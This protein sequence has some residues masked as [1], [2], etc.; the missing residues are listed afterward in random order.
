MKTRTPLKR[1]NPSNL[2]LMT[3][4]LLLAVSLFFGAASISSFFMMRRVTAQL[5]DEQID[6]LRTRVLVAT[7]L[8][9]SDLGRTMSIEA[10]S[11]QDLQ[12]FTKRLKTDDTLEVVVTDIH[13]Q[14]RETTTKIN[15]LEH[16]NEILSAVA[17][18]SAWGQDNDQLLVFEPLR[19]DRKVVGIVAFKLDWS[20]QRQMLSQIAAWLWSSA[21]AT[22]LFVSFAV[23]FAY[24][25]LNREA[26]RRHRA[27]SAILEQAP[28]GIYT[29]DPSG[30]IDTFNPKMVELAGASSAEKVIGLNVF[31]MPSY[32]EANLI[33]DIR[34]A[35]TG[36]PFD[37]EVE[38]VSFTAG[39]RTW[40]H[41]RGV[42]LFLPGGVKLDR[43]L[44]LVEDITERKDLEQKNLEHA[45]QVEKYAWEQ[46]QQLA[47][48]DAQLHTVIDQLPV[49]FWAIDAQGNFTIC[50]GSGLTALGLKGDEAIGRSILEIYRADREFISQ[51]NRALAGETFSAQAAL[52]ER[53]YA[54]NYSSLRDDRGGIIGAT[55]VSVD[56]TEQARTEQ[57]FRAMVN[58]SVDVMTVIDRHGTIVFGTE[59]TTRVFGYA[60]KDFMDKPLK[61]FIHPDDL[62]NVTAKLAECM[63]V[64]GKI[65]SVIYRF[66]HLDGHY[67]DVESI[68]Q[69]FLEE[70]SI[71]G[72]VINTR[73]MTERV[74]D[75]RE[76][77]HN[78][79]TQAAI[80][81]LGQAIM[82]ENRQ[83]VIIEA[84]AK[85]VKAILEADAT[86][87]LE[88]RAATEDFLI[89]TI[90]G[91]PTGH[92]VGT[93]LPGNVHSQAG[94]AVL[95]RETV[96]VEDYAKES[97]FTAI[98]MG[99]TDQIRSGVSVIIGDS[100][101]P[102]GVL[103][104]FSARPRTLSPSDVGFLE[105]VAHLIGIGLS[106]AASEYKS[107]DL[108]HLKSKFIQV[109]S[110][111]FRAPLSAVRWNLESLLSGDVGELTPETR[112]FVRITYEA[113]NEVINRIHDLLT[114]LDIEE[115]RITLNPE[116]IS[117]DSIVASVAAEFTKRAALKRLNFKYT[118]PA[119]ASSAVLLDQERVRVILEKLLD[120]ALAY[121]PSG[122][123][124]TLATERLEGRL[125]VTI[126]DTGIG[127]PLQEQGRLFERFYRASNASTMRPD[128]SGLGLTIAKYFVEQQD[129]TLGFTSKEG[130]GSTFW[131]ELPI[132]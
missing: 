106:R 130:G 2:R 46:S 54:H 129:G 9:P 68:G 20:R 63:T 103:N 8:L 72:I 45:Q 107:R 34:Q 76:I 102:W 50:E 112:E 39:R 88:Y 19:R 73:D 14:P 18:G 57:R 128:A 77:R 28:I 21:I 53:I 127:I 81:A 97:R 4:V 78:V 105:S 100:H 70:A 27:L 49:V 86:A 6:E 30:I 42:P 87:V 126:T 15:L 92:A 13:G 11:D 114:V 95:T 79:A 52:G 65:V 94:Y 60:M 119:Q 109:V 32:R 37:K 93:I 121:T 82:M 38:Y 33:E 43:L 98:A 58:N 12:S 56:V 55:G 104:A 91:E 25:L 116:L 85:A 117:F 51:V 5:R 35:L 113:N 131:F 26:R 40:R 110:H 16:Q 118:P 41:Y 29:L 69:N 90:I 23:W 74:R 75:E 80:A 111:Q 66:R 89:K 62:S 115:R 84:G 1:P 123:T 3:T 132:K 83:E 67:V 24:R 120:N 61:K 96:I 124:V 10:V 22:A 44:L 108:D 59:A 101:Q 17:G 71:R 64:P 99:M 31:E 48:K 7:D 125:R 47:R 36:K 122:G